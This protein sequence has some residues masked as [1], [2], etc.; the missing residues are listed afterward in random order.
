MFNL[1]QNKLIATTTL[2]VQG[3]AED[4][5]RIVEYR[6]NR[7]DAQG[8]P[9]NMSG[10]TVTATDLVMDRLPPVA[11]LSAGLLFQPTAKLA[12]R[13]TVYNALVGHYYMPDVN[14]DFEPHLE[15]LAQPYEG[16]RAY[17]SAMYQY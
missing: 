15:Y 2:R 3:A 5:N 16:F 1:I 9:S 17:V 12:V 13:A 7:F 10:V 11:E 8:N 14:Y 4:P 6:D